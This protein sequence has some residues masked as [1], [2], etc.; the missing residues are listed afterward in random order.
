MYCGRGNTC[1][2]NEDIRYGNYSSL[3]EAK[4]GCKN[5][6]SCKLVMDRRCDNKGPFELCK[7]ER[8]CDYDERFGILRLQNQLNKSSSK[9]LI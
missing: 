5:D 6:K 1:N 7:S 9:L 2:I 3:K 4:N 8:V